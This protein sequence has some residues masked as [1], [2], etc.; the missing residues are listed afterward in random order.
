MIPL[1][2]G[3]IVSRERDVPVFLLLSNAMYDM[4]L[5]LAFVVVSGFCHYLD[6]E[7]TSGN[8]VLLCVNLV[9]IWYMTRRSYR[10]ERNLYN[11]LYDSIARQT[12][13]KAIPLQERGE[14][15]ST[16]INAYEGLRQDQRKASQEN[17]LV[18][19]VDMVFYLLIIFYTAQMILAKI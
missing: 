4:K 11:S 18:R 6:G 19:I 17:R 13:L 5:L 10:M 2:K 1:L 15:L 16:I 14:T 9:L 8:T 12:N 3:F 7:W